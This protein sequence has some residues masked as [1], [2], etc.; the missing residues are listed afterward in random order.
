MRPTVPRRRTAPLKS[1]GPLERARASS[2][3]TFTDNGDGTYTYVMAI[4][5]DNVTTPLVVTYEPTRTHRVAMQLSGNVSN[6]FLDFRPD[7][8]AVTETR[9]VSDDASCNECHLKLGLHGGDR[10]QV[11]YCVTCHNPGS[12][13]ANSGNTVDFKVM[14]HKIHAGEHG[15]D[16]QAG[17]EYAIWGFGNSKHDYSTVDYPQDLRNCTKCH[18]TGTATPD[19]DNWKDVPST[20]ACTSCHEAP[21]PADYPTFP[22]LTP[23]EIEEAHEILAQVA[24]AAFEYNIISIAGTNP[25][26]TPSVTFSVTD[27]TNADAPYDILTDPAFTAGRRCQPAGHPDRLG[28]HGLHQYRQRQHAG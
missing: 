12:T 9:D 17:G 15:P 2:G 11:D 14:I 1:R 4:D 3:G 21:D 7:T 13:D 22:N 5:V 6:A 24:A 26:E 8:L 16:V 10:I 23:V 20:A 18:E 25:G 19:G 28:D 27:P